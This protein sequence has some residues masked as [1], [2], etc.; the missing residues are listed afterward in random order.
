MIER[1]PH[2][3]AAKRLREMLRDENDS[4][5]KALAE[6]KALRVDSK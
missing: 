3:E 5:Q 2:M 4:Y 1:V 6:L